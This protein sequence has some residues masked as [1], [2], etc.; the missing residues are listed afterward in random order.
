MMRAHGLT[1]DGLDECARVRVVDNEGWSLYG[2]QRAQQ[3][4]T[5]VKSDGTQNGSTSENRCRGFARSSPANPRAPQDLT[6][7]P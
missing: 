7:R 4:A 2:A 1:S 3:V 5:G 6:A